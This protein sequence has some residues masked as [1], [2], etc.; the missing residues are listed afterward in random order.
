MRAVVTGGASFIGSHLVD[1]LVA[2]GHQVLV[3]DDCS[4]GQWENIK[5]PDG[6]AGDW[7]GVPLDLRDVSIERLARTIKDA[8]V[9]FHLAANHGGR[10]YVETR[11]IACS[12]N[13]AIDN[14]VFQAVTRAGVPKVIFASS[15][16]IYPLWMQNDVNDVVRLAEED[17]DC[18][19][20]FESFRGFDPDGLYGLAKLAGEL[21][22]E[23]MHRE[24]GTES[25]SC[26]F[27]TVYGPKAK[28]NHAIMSFIA[29]AF[30][31]QN[32]WT[33]WGDGTQ[34]RNWTY[35]DDIVNGMMVA[36]DLPGCQALNLGTTEQIT[37][38]CAVESV[39]DI[40]N[41]H[42]YGGAYHPSVDYDSTKPTGPMV[43]VADNS[44]YLSLP[45]SKTLTTFRS[46]LRSTL[47]WY[48]Q[49]KD[50]DAV[51]RDLERLLIERR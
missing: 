36:V 43:R 47:V 24:F 28:E 17:Y 2:E 30:T 12:N 49:N 5:Q 51:S 31:R 3:I 19:R 18:G 37:V 14:N 27:F 44:K 6:S 21:T 8:D 22:L 42:F 9:V 23:H 15:G 45:G 46:G 29:R 7:F 32:P 4:S 10:G 50:R 34:V 11:Q 40:A 16:C 41:A 35:V 26:R 13:F 25:V 39:I 48:F 1:R 20:M 33:V 38:R